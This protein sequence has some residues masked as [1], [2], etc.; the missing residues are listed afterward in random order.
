MRA[1]PFTLSGLVVSLALLVA[2]GPDGARPSAAQS[3][4][5]TPV[6]LV[7]LARSIGEGSEA[8]T[9]VKWG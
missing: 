6:A 3:Q 5:V 8:A 1:R 4:G 2:L 9:P 7:L